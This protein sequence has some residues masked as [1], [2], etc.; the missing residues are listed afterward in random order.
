MYLVPPSNQSG[1]RSKL[2]DHEENDCDLESASVIKL[3]PGNMEIVEVAPRLDRLK[4]LLSQVPYGIDDATEMEVEG[5]GKDKTGLYKWDDLVNEVQASDE[6]LRSGLQALLAVEIDGYWRLVDETYMDMI[7][8]ML[9]HNSILLDWP[10]NA[11]DEVEVLGILESDGFPSKVAYHCLSVYGDKLEV[12]GCKCF[13]KLNEKR[14]AV[15]FARNILR[16]G[17][18]KMDNFLEEWRQKVPTGIEASLQILEGEVLTEKVGIETW[19]R[20]FSTSSLPS[21]PADR[22]SILFKER[23]RWDWKDLQ[24]YTRY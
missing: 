18:M 7:L 17:K 12:G 5:V 10:L 2:Q 6:E 9:L 20:A 3:A 19:I 16:E 24:P 21:T 14:V 11:L 4:S 8:K 15:H 23:P 22:F 13:W 1:T